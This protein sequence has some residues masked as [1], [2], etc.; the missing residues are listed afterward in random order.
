MAS[1]LY[2][3]LVDDGLLV[4]HEEVAAPGPRPARAYK[5][6]AP[7]RIPFVSYPYEWSF[8][9]L[10]QAALATLEI[11][12]RARERGMSLKDASGF[13]IQFVGHR[14]VLID[15]LSFQSHREAAPWVAYRQFC[16]H[17]L[18]P[19]AL[20][21]TRDPCLGQLTRR[22]VDGIPLELA[23]KLLPARTWFSLLTLTHIHLHARSQRRYAES[24]GAPAP[25]TLS[26]GAERAILENLRSGVEG[27]QPART[28]SRWPT[29]VETRS[30]SQAAMD[31]K[32]LAVAQYLDRLRPSYV[33]DLGANTG[34]IS[35]LASQ[36]G[37]Y[38]VAID[39]DPDSVEINYRESARA[40]DARI[41]PLVVD[42]TNPSPRLGWHHRERL[43]LL[44]RGPADMVL[45]LA[46]I[47]HLAIGNNVPLPRVASFLADA[48]NWAVVEF[49][50]KEDEQVQRLMRSR[51][52]VFDD[53]TRA[54]F[55]RAFAER[56]VLEDR[57][58]LPGSTRVLYL[59]R[60]LDG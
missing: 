19:L 48:G 29:Y 20:M 37:A 30:Y 53:Y 14:A 49:V 7:Q 46:L 35:R 6:I 57:R 11:Q 24:N 44:E 32:S 47:H 28:S 9:Q 27:L 42:L 1:G 22:F 25:G 43:S 40:H 51:T 16:Q 5:V 39:S 54:G 38:T 12:R 34:E 4:P 36:K 26:Q 23:S 60:R 18:A 45:A 15:T 59:Y 2:Q 58:A 33:W 8:S 50:P 10:Q 56:F 41:L 31:H 13:N 52:D 55:E 17:F 3:S 21:S